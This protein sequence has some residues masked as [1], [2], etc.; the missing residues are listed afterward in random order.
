MY[1][2]NNQ[3][4]ARHKVGLKYQ[5]T[6][7]CGKLWSW[8]N[9]DISQFFRLQRTTRQ[10]SRGNSLRPSLKKPGFQWNAGLWYDWLLRWGGEDT[11]HVT[12]EANDWRKVYVYIRGTERGW[13]RE[14]EKRQVLFKNDNT[15]TECYEIHLA[16]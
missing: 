8:L 9:V 6:E 4:S 13:K 1:P 16:S 10:R 2:P 12:V 14:E 5:D 3:H 7:K 15:V 11:E